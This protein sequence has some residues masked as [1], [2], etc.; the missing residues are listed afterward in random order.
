VI[1]RC[2]QG[3]FTARNARIPAAAAAIPAQSIHMSGPNARREFEIARWAAGSASAEVGEVGLDQVVRAG[4][5]PNGAAVGFVGVAMV[6][7]GV[8]ASS[9]AAG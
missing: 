9:G 4:V 1:V 2:A 7:D 5:E 8:F 3:S 6:V